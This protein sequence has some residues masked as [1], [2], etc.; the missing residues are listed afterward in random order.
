[1]ILARGERN[2]GAIGLN[3]KSGTDD[4]RERPI[5]DLVEK[6][7]GEGPKLKSF[8]R[9]A[10]VLRLIGA[11]KRYIDEVIPSIGKLMCETVKKAMEKAMEKAV[12]DAEVVVVGLDVNEIMAD[13]QSLNR[14]G[15]HILDL[16]GIQNRDQLEAELQGVCW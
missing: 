11:N 9:E 5:V 6:M 7:I 3:F 10:S 16:V 2:V 1:M 13:V 4:L 8:D 12:E 14:S 15:R